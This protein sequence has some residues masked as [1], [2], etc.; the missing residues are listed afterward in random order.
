MRR[1]ESQ[2]PW[3]PQSE[4]DWK[5]PVLSVSF[6]S[7]SC[8]CSVGGGGDVQ[9]SL[10]KLAHIPLTRCTAN[11]RLVSVCWGVSTDTFREFVTGV[12]LVWT[13][14][15]TTT[16][17]NLTVKPFCP[18]FFKGPQGNKCFHIFKLLEKKVFVCGA[19]LSMGRIMFIRKSSGA[20]NDSSQIKLQ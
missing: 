20:K 14:P 6:T 1:L 7:L 16:L 5:F 12:N 15:R 11:C 4:T 3:M 2:R 18:A 9:L 19:D 8:S 10:R 13:C 17:P